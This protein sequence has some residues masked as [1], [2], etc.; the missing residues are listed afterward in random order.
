MNLT[1]KRILRLREPVRGF[2]AGDN[3]ARWRGHLREA[4]SRT[5][6]HKH[7]PALPFAEMAGFMGELKKREGIASRVL[8]FLILTATR[9]NEVIGAR[10]AEIDDREKVWTV[11]GA[12]MKSGREHRVPLSPQAV[13]LLK[14]LPREGEF[15]FVGARAGQSLS[16]MAMLQVMKALRPGFVPHGFRATFRTWTAERGLPSVGAKGRRHDSP[17]RRRKTQRAHGC[18]L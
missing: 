7:H 2:R 1:S 4:L 14:N 12:R 13:A 11:P 3:P 16:N 5:V 6:A 9:T 10:W 15:V 18:Q 17:N 8:E